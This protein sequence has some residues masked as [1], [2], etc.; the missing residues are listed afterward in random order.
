MRVTINKQFVKDAED[1]LVDLADIASAAVVVRA[2]ARCPV[3]SGRLQN[4]IRRVKL[5]GGG[6]AVGS[7][8]PYASN[9]EYGTSKQRAQP[10]LRPALDSLKTDPPSIDSVSSR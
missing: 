6:Y 10:F 1:R 4:S 3:R 7:G 9:V 5:P 8:V 2:K